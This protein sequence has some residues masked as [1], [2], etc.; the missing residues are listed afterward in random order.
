VANYKKY[1]VAGVNRN[2]PEDPGA[3]IDK[4]NVHY[5]TLSV[6]TAFAASSTNPI[7]KRL[8]FC[9]YFFP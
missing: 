4:V 5:K 1:F 2:F 7:D 8:D 3:I 9:A 6:D